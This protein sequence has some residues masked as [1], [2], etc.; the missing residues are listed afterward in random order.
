MYRLLLESIPVHHTTTKAVL[1][2]LL[3]MVKG[4]AGLHG[5]TAAV[6]DRSSPDCV[7]REF[8]SLLLLKAYWT[9]KYH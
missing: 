1:H 9:L 6:T 7:G 5:T 4:I 2:M 8:S 3:L